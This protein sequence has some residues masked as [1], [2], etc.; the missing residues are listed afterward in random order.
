MVD[1]FRFAWIESSGSVPVYLEALPQESLIGAEIGVRAG[2]NLVHMLTSCTKIKK[3]FAIDPYFPYSEGDGQFVTQ[4]DQDLAKTVMLHRL[5]RTG[6]IEKVELLCKTSDDAVDDIMDESLD[7]V[8]ID[9]DHSE[10]FVRRDIYN[11]YNKVKN[12]GIVSGHDFSFADV[13]KVL[14]EFM[15]EKN[16][17]TI[18][19]DKVTDAWFFYKNKS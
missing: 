10:E 19:H 13:N 6:L 8:F 7:F 1:I 16:I 15:I 14:S 17:E 18:C 5:K 11:Y 4:E 9:G 2:T 12:G 3:I